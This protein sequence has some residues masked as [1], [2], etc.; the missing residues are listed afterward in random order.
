MTKTI[1]VA[2]DDIDIRLLVTKALEPLGHTIITA[3]NG[4]QALEMTD[5][6]HPDLVITDLVMPHGH[7]FGL[8]K[9]LRAR[10]DSSC[11]KIL[12]LSSKAYDSD[13]RQVMELG[14]DLF[15]NKPFRVDELQEA[16]KT[17]LNEPEE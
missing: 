4:E 17:L 1:L 3:V 16:V 15:M 6:H 9:A 11:M 2:D 5:Q 13:R 8:C 7:G 14:A 12:V 10:G